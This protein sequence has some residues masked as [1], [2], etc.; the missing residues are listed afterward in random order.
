MA[1]ENWRKGISG[2][3]TYL[4]NDNPKE[5]APGCGPNGRKQGPINASIYNSQVPLSWHVQFDDKGNATYCGRLDNQPGV[6]EMSWV[7]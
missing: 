4:C 7:Q 1:T 3:H 6:L 2:R 5:H